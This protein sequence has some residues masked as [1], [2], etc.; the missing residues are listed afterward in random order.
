MFK[1]AI[2]AAQQGLAYLILDKG[3]DL[4]LAMQDAM[5]EKKFLLVLTLLSK[6]PNDEVVQQCNSKGQNLCHILSMNAGGCSFEHLKRIYLT[7]L[8]RGVN[9]KAKDFY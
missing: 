6:N 8:K 2:R 3:Y 1:V 4:M 9:C 7:L 5:D